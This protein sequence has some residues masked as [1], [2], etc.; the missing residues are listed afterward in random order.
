[1]VWSFDI[2]PPDTIFFKPDFLVNEYAYD[3]DSGIV[4]KFLL[5]NFDRNVVSAVQ[6]F[7]FSNLK[8]VIRAR[9]RGVM[10]TVL[11]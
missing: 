10:H 3:T 4:R 1:M 2:T 11:R 5:R 7:Y 9:Y 6:V 8:T